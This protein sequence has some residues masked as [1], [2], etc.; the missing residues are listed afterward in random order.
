[1]DRQPRVLVVGDAFEDLYFIG[2]T[3]RIS[4][5]APIPVV[6]ITE[7]LA[8]PG[9]SNNVVHNLIALGANVKGRNGWYGEGSLL[10]QKNRL[11]VGDIQIARWD[12]YDEVKAIRVEQLEQAVDDWTPDA[13]VVSDYG[14]GSVSDEVISWVNS[15]QIPLF[16]D[17]KDSPARFY[18]EA[19]F[20]P[21]AQEYDTHE[22]NYNDI[23]EV[24]LKQGAGGISRLWRGTLQEW[25]PAYAKNVVSVC[26]AGDTVIA[27]YAYFTILGDPAALF[28]ASVAAAV[29]VEKPWTATAS[30]TEIE[31]RIK[32]LDTK[33]A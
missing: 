13:I 22:K 11:M 32:C 31:E 10:P 9:G 29:V 21:N 12:E 15:Q 14:K 27:A 2:T 8:Y 19:T 18:Y 30:V 1:M 26:G 23:E 7:H 6:K 20:F 5:E 3:T 28:K 17:T 25:F 16:V 33:K 24:I 4:P